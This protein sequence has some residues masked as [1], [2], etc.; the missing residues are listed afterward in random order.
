MVTPRGIE[1]LIPPWKGGVLTAWPRSHI[2]FEKTD[3]ENLKWRL[4]RDSN[5][6]PPAWQAGT[7]T[8]WATKPHCGGNNRDR[9][10]DPLLVRQMLSQLSYAP[11][12]NFLGIKLVEDGGFEPP[13]RYA[14]DLQSAPFGHSGNSPYLTFNVL[15]F[16]LRTRHRQWLVYNH[17]RFISSP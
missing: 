13:K 4:R 11:M 17:Y 15:T 6:R 1:P 16:S 7:L 14:T 12:H 10:C 8:N 2:M 5:P 9:T 3:I